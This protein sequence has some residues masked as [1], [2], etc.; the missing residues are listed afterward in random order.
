M[1]EDLAKRHFDKANWGE[2]KPLITALQEKG[3]DLSGAPA[4]HPASA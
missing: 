1:A 3:V 2:I 4:R